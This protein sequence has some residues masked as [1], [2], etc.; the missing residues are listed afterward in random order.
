MSEPTAQGF[1]SRLVTST[2]TGQLNGTIDYDWQEDGVVITLTI[3][4][5]TLDSPTGHYPGP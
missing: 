1:G 2:T 4:L 3:P 5:E